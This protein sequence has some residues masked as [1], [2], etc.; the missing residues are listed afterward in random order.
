LGQT[1]LRRPPHAGTSFLQRGCAPQFSQ[2]GLPLGCPSPSRS[3]ASANVVP[4]RRREAAA[5]PGPRLFR[6]RLHLQHLAATLHRRTAG[7]DAPGSPKAAGGCH[8]CSGRFR[9]ASIACYEA[10][11]GGC[12]AA[13]IVPGVVDRGR[14]AALLQAEHSGHRQASA[15]RRLASESTT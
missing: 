8:P 5:M 4:I 10:V 1:G 2:T 13:E 11:S 14:L 12:K 9:T 3:P 7:T 15:A 6:R